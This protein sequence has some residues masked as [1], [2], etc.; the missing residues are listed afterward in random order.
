MGPFTAK[1]EGVP[2]STSLTPPPPF[3]T[4]SRVLG[5]LGPLLF[6]VCRMPYPL[7]RL[8]FVTKVS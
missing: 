1:G 6:A 4:W 2:P 5:L 8:L 7:S 3:H